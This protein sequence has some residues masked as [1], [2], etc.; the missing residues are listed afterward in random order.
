MAWLGRISV[1]VA[2]GGIAHPHVIVGDSGRLHSQG[3]APQYWILAVA[4]MTSW[5]WRAFYWLHFTRKSV[6]GRIE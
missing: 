5:I 1:D 3:D 4:G 2:I 6:S